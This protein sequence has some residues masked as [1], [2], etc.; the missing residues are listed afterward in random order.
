MNKT[1]LVRFERV[2]HILIDEGFGDFF[3]KANIIDNL[4]FREKIKLPFERKLSLSNRIKS[5]AMRCG[6][7]FVHFVKYL[8][9]R[10]DV[11]DPRIC[12]ELSNIELAQIKEKA[13]IEI[14]DIKIRNKT[15][16]HNK[17]KPLFFDG[18]SYR[19]SVQSRSKS[20][21][22][23][24][25][26]QI[27]FLENKIMR[28]YEQDISILG[29]FA[30][31][32]DSHFKYSFNAKRITHDYLT[33]VHQRFHLKKHINYAQKLKG[34][35]L[36][37]NITL[38]EYVKNASTDTHLVLKP[39]EGIAADEIPK[40]ILAFHEHNAKMMENLSSL[41]FSPI[42]THGFLVKEIDMDNIILQNKGSVGLNH[43]PEIEELN[44]IDV[45]TIS[46]FF[47]GLIT[48][49]VTEILETFSITQEK[50][51][52]NKLEKEITK[53]LNR[54]N[55]LQS[56]HIEKILETIHEKQK[57]PVHFF[58]V[59]QLMHI[60]EEIQFH[61][62]IKRTI[63][64][65]IQ[66][67]VEKSLKALVRND[68]VHSIKLTKAQKILFSKKNLETEISLVH[69]ASKKVHTHITFWGFSILVTLTFLLILELLKV[70]VKGT[71][72]L[73]ILL[74]C[75]LLTLMS[76]HHLIRHTNL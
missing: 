72:I 54:N 63:L 49:N 9:T 6:P 24:E 22:K 70:D 65:L 27:H 39:M 48:K 21:K 31:V 23:N 74:A 19:C 71:Q 5:A 50:K 25:H 32:I 40:A 8:S 45:A 59:V 38:P 11:L 68:L 7:T 28:K 30:S 56:K 66:P 42:F 44:K 3:V 46:A 75:I 64:L 58:S 36:K 43:I 29:F 20:S 52:Y 33:L 53:I 2:S 76:R 4:S 62:Q 17:K 67:H 41:L 57:I 18:F 1:E 34:A 12:Y 61:F 51:S 37:K 60:C 26:Y 69:V 10:T 13:K 14:P 15:F 47:G 35:L 73:V 55:H 16:R